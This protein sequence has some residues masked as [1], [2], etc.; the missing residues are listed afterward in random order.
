MDGSEVLRVIAALHETGVTAGISGGW[1]IDALLGRQTRP[2]GDV[3]LGIDATQ[4]DLALSQ[5]IQIG[6]R[7]V[8][9]ERPARVELAAEAGRVDLHPIDWNDDGTGIQTGFEAERFVYP[10]GSL[11]APGTV[12][13]ESVRCA[14]PEL[15]LAFHN[16]TSHASTIFATWPR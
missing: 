4:L 11:D 6:Y 2:H 7:V 9:D 16:H 5:L 14:T 15:Q 3:D 1:G 12:D 13:G 10:P 8:R